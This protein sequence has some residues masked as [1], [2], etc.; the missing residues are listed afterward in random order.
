MSDTSLRL[1]GPT[2]Y[3]AVERLTFAAF[4]TMELPGRTHTNEH[5][6]AHLLRDDP[7]FV[8]ELDFV[9]VR[10]GEL[11]GSIM[12]SKCG[13]IRPDGTVSDALVF[14]PVSVK[15]ELHRQG[16]GTLLIQHSLHRAR[17]LG[18][19]AVLITGHPGYY[20]RFGF[21]PAGSFGLTMPNGASFDAF[22]ALELEDGYLGTAGGKWQWCH[23]FDVCEN[24]EAAFQKYQKDFTGQ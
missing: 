3:E 14:G 20:H 23:A 6:L 15:P 19:R 8:P 11:I 1:E 22:M 21:I 12:Y 9:A 5:F 13:I 18:Y 16:V 24:D 17:A 4:E 2:D 7:G 10:D